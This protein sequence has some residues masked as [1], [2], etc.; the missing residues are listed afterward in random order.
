MECGVAI[1]PLN[2]FLSECGDAVRIYQTEDTCELFL[3]DV[4]GHGAGARVVAE[5]AEA[6]LDAHHGDEL[7]ALFQ[8]LHAHLLGTR[9]AVAACCRFHRETETLEFCGIGNITVKII[10]DKSESM[11]SRDGVI[12]YHTISPRLTVTPLRPGSIVLMHSDGVKS[13]VNYTMQRE[14]LC[15]NA[16]D[17]A[18]AILR[19]YGTK[20]DDASCIVMKYLH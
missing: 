8:G 4:L 15:K 1:R 14:L 18:Q 12:G 3:V 2:R 7:T 6:W 10:R 16:G 5:R 20:L 11:V 19:E 13:T 17:M 9:G